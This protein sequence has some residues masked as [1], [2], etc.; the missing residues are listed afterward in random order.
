[1][2]FNYF[3]LFMIASHY[4]NSSDT[5]HSIFWPLV[6]ALNVSVKCSFGYV[7]SIFLSFSCDFVKGHSPWWAERTKIWEKWNLPSV[8]LLRLSRRLLS[9][10]QIEILYSS[11]F[12]LETSIQKN[13]ILETSIQKNC[14]PL[15]LDCP[16]N[17]KLTSKVVARI[18]WDNIRNLSA[19]CLTK[20]DFW[21]VSWLPLFL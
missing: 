7:C 14:L 16:I 8:Y 2:L 4:K 9:R 20:V 21:Q 15:C 12:I 5:N 10:K 18:K 13:Y 1:M 19:H 17:L 3:S 11:S 6:R